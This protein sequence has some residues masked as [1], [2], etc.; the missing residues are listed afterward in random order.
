MADLTI[1]IPSQDLGDFYRMLRDFRRNRGNTFAYLQ[2]EIEQRY[3]KL[4]E[5]YGN[6]ETV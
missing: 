4:K 1:T 6:E 5:R 3:P 2:I